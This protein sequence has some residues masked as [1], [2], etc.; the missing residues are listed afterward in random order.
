[1]QFIQGR[2]NKIY[3]SMSAA[4][5]FVP[6]RVVH[7]DGLIFSHGYIFMQGM[8]IYLQIVPFHINII[9]SILLVP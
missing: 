9:I 4:P 2:A 7:I 1:M 5:L 3:L 6:F 8:N